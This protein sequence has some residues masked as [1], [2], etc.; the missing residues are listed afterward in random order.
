MHAL[1][2]VALLLILIQGL[3]LGILFAGLIGFLEVPLLHAC[4]L[5]LEFLF[6]PDLYQQMQQGQTWHLR[7]GFCRK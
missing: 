1:H 6:S 7:E 5:W 4:I 3:Q 2:F